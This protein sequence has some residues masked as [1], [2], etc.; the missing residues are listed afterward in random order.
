MSR[1]FFKN[2]EEFINI[3]NR[4]GGDSRCWA[5]NGKFYKDYKKIVDGSNLEDFK[6]DLVKIFENPG[7]LKPMFS[8]RQGQHEIYFDD[9]FRIYFYYFAKIDYIC[10]YEISHKDNQKLKNFNNKKAKELHKK[11][12]NIAEMYSKQDTHGIQFKVKI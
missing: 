3:L 9:S 7:R 4:C 6:N 1:H 8:K 12:F 11:I 5:F 2:K 10:F